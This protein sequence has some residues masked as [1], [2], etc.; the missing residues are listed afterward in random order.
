MTPQEALY[1]YN[2]NGATIE[3][4]I[5]VES[6]INNA[7]EKQIP[8]KPRVTTY[9]YICNGKEES[10]FLKHCP[11]CFDNLQIGYFDSIVNKDSVYCR[12]CGQRLDW[13]ENDE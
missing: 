6:I 1:W 5:E 8:K 13:S 11:N 10:M 7:L 2:H 12:R 9:Q 3:Q 4:E